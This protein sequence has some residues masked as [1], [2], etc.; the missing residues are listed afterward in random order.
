MNKISEKIKNVLDEMAYV[1]PVNASCGF[2]W[3]EVDMPECLRKELEEASKETE[4]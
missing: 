3:G 2:V 1:V 4:M